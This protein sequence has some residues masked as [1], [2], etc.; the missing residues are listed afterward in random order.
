VPAPNSIDTLS[1][2]PWMSRDATVAAPDAEADQQ[3]QQQ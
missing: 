1:F 2:T 3:Q